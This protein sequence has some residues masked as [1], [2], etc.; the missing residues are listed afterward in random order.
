MRK[1]LLLLSFLVCLIGQLAAQGRVVTG[2]VTDAGGAPI[3]GASITIKGSNRGTSTGTDGTFSLSVTSADKVLIISSVNLAPQ[4]I[5]IQ[6]KTSIGSIGLQ[7]ANKSLEEVVVVAYGTQKK[8]N[9]TGAVTTVSGAQ[10]ADKPFTSVDKALQGNVAGLQSS[11]T[12]GAPGSST[13]IIIRGIGSINASAQPLWVIDGTIATTGDLT[14]NTTTAN[15]LST[16]NPDDI[17]SISVLKDAISTAPYGSRGANGVI[18]VTTKKGKAGKTHFNITGEAGQNSRAF[19]PT[20]KPLTTLQYQDVLRQ[21][22]INPGYAS[23]NAGA[24]ALITDPNFLGFP[25]NWTTF[26]TDWFKVVSQNGAQSQVNMSLSGG[27]DKT[28]VYASGGYF[29][30]K[31]TSIASDFQRWNGAIAVTHKASDRFTLSAN[32]NGSNTSQTTPTNGGTFANPVLASFFLMP[33]FTPKNADGSLRFGANDDM[34]EFPVNGGIFNPLVQ[35]AYNT[36]L[37]QQTALRGNVTGE[38]RILDNLKFTSRFAAEYLAVQEDAYQNPFYGDGYPKGTAQSNYNRVFDYTWSN[39]ADW[40]QKVNNDGDVYFDFKAG[41]EAYDFKNYSLQT[42]GSNFPQT[43]A[44]KYLASASTPLTSFA[45]PSE[46]TTF[47]YFGIADFNY[48]DRYIIAGSIRRDESSVFGADHRWGTFYSIG[49]SW[50][51]NEEDFMKNQGLFNLL[52]LRASYGQTGNTNGFGL[53]T[54][55]PTYSGGANYSG[56]P[57]LAPSNVGDPNL[58]WEKNKASNI[59]L[60]FGMFKDR[61]TGT[62]E[63]YHRTTDGLL[64]AVPFSFT[65]GFSSQNENIGAVVNKGIEVTLSGRPIV[66]RDF[67]W[68]ISFNIAHNINRVTQLYQNKPIPNG[69][70]EYTIG[71]D[72]QE[73]YLQQWAGVDPATGAPLWYT[74]GTHKTTTGD[75]NAAGLALN[76]SADPKIYGG[77]TN[78]FIYKGFTLDVQF[79]Y[80]YG[81]YIFDNWYNYLNSDGQELGGFNQLSDQLHAWQKAG[82]K[83]DVPQLIIGGNNFSNSPSTR[84]LYNGN[85]IRLR[86]LQFMYTFP[87]DLMKRAHLGSVS[88]YVRGTN[89]LSLGVD[90]RLPFD[91][92]AGINSTTNLEVLIPKT[93]TGGIRIGL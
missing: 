43:L 69:T 74:D 47:S 84:W 38:Y 16:L 58:T 15:V 2:T 51:I 50:N 53:Y 81:N 1:T 34:G 48:K 90:K 66:T 76:K 3:A 80:N 35:A 82:D 27:N 26:N 11:S 21:S 83:T 85:Y 91:P 63:Y 77:L 6:N 45:L 44:L 60:D 19:N 64:S 78:T 65:S 75:Y 61:L 89:L 54:S 23:D 40:K 87:Q 59:G 29:N 39:F 52:K 18:L 93:I 4:E 8:T 86:N 72:L 49:G 12:S 55:L 56:N 9:L 57:G 5:N 22:I 88:I 92:E 17:E 62:V 33:W 24:D 32:L 71:H 31:G 14:V 7:P 20:N 13:D 10:V 37:A 46:Q 25:A 79:N 67:T 73:Y 42:S 68:Q 36:N 41:V 30:Q 70:F 28:Q